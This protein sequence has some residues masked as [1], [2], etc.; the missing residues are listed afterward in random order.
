MSL[1][2]YH[3]FYS[4]KYDDINGHCIC[5][6]FENKRVKITML[7]RIFNQDL[8]NKYPDIIYVGRIRNITG[9]NTYKKI[10]PKL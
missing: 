9:E 6:T 3:G 4:K 8:F 2:I 5:E 1:K 7:N 10:D